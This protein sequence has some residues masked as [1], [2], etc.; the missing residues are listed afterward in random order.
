MQR[1]ITKE[2]PGPE[3]SPPL[4]ALVRAQGGAVRIRANDGPIRL[5]AFALSA[6]SLGRAV[7]TLCRGGAASAAWL[8]TAIAL[9]SRA[10]AVSKGK[11][12]DG[13]DCEFQDGFHVLWMDD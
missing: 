10:G 12:S 5:H 7:A 4:P 6:V 1:E 2:T 9:L 3:K 13:E 8:A 11:A